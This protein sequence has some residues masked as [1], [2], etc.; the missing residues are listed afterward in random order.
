ML[1]STIVNTVLNNHFGTTQKQVEVKFYDNGVYQFSSF[2]HSEHL[3][4]AAGEN[5]RDLGKTKSYL[6]P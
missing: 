5:W 2:Y 1:A 6:I 3:A 4:W